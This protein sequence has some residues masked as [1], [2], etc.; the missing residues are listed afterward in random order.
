MFYQTAKHPSPMA[1]LSIAA[2]GE[3]KCNEVS[4]RTKSSPRAKGYSKIHAY[5]LLLS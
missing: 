1:K 3:R 2:S 5:I 4:K